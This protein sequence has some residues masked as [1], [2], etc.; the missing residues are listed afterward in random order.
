MQAHQQGTEKHSGFPIHDNVLCPSP[1]LSGEDLHKGL[2]F[3]E[4]KT[5]KRVDLT[6]TC[7]LKCAVSGNGK[8]HLIIVLAR[9]LASL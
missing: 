9:H 6:Q 8:K 3:C 5:G 2:G 7:C 4:S 1:Q